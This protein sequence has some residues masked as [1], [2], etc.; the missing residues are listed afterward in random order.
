MTAVGAGAAMGQQWDI[1]GMVDAGMVDASTQGW[2]HNRRG[3]QQW[4]KL[5]APTSLPSFSTSDPARCTLEKL[6]TCLAGLCIL[7]LSFKW[8]HRVQYTG[9]H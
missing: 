5:F 8:F 1:A 3:Q 2:P 7:G 9:N 6:E 4:Y